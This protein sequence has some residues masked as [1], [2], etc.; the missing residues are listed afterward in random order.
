MNHTI[1]FLDGTE[2]TFETLRDANLPRAN[3]RDADL[4][5]AD[6]SGANLSGAN[7]SWADLSGANLSWADLSGADLRGANLR[8]ANLRGADLCGADLSWA[9]LSGADLAQT[10]LCEANLSRANLSCADLS[11]ANLGNQWIIQGPPRSDEY[12]FFLQKLTADSQPMIKAGCRHFTLPEAWKHWRATRSGTPLGEE[13]FAILEYLEKVAR[14]Q[15]RIL[16]QTE[17]GAIERAADTIARAKLQFEGDAETILF[18]VVL[19]LLEWC[20]AQS[21]KINFD[22]VLDMVR[23]HIAEHPQKG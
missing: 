2:K 20:G 18:H 7:L 5:G 12:H 3:L 22:E 21:P 23:E 16:K 1:K 17:Y 9:N 14:I 8:G 6:L 11:G 4:S 13:T 15:G 19:D 10:D